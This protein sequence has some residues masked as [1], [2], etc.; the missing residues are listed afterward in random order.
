MG[1]TWRFC[2]TSGAR[3]VGVIHISLNGLFIKKV[4]PYCNNMSLNS[5]VIDENWKQID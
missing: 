5:M 4:H 2:F 3:Y 1:I